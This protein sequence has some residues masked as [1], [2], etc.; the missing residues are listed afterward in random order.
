MSQFISFVSGNWQFCLLH[1]LEFAIWGA[2]FV[3]LGNLLNARGFS[4]KEIGRIYGTIPIGTM[5]ASLIV[6]GIADKYLNMEWVIGGSH[7]F[8]AVMLFLMAKT[9]S[10]KKFF[11]LALMYA[12]AFAPTLSLVNAIFFANDDLIVNAPADGGFPWVR[13]FGTIGWIVAGM[14]HAVLLKKGEPVNERPLLLASALSLVLGIFA[15]TLPATPPK[16]A[17]MSETETVAML[18]EVSGEAMASSAEGSSDTEVASSTEET[19]GGDEESPADG[20]VDSAATD[21]GHWYDPIV[22]IA[23]GIRGMLVDHPVFF[24]VTLVASMA[25]GLYFAFAA[26][27]LEKTGVPSRTVGPVMTIGQWIEIFFMLSLP[28][29]IKQYGMNWV[30]AIGISA[31]ALRFGLFA[32]GRPLPLVLFGV[33]IHGICFDFFFAAGMT[34][35]DNIAS[36]GLQATAQGVYAFIVYGLGMYLGSEGSGWLNDRLSRSSVD[37][38]GVETTTTHWRTFWAIPCVLVTIATVMFLLT[39]GGEPADDQDDQQSH[40]NGE[41]KMVPVRETLA[42]N[43]ELHW[44]G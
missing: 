33:A 15:F 4:R 31:W 24:F 20:A 26:L 28:W 41:T 44:E 23:N 12:I 11:V 30:L 9:F 17:T 7:L 10:A 39:L 29:F 14:S 21:A 22:T 36:E 16:P 27:F 5:A 38:D 2:W 8:G 18:D 34:H 25:M 13:V 19:A 6:G 43:S 32:I 3:V 35:A 40:W 42:E 1:F 37:E